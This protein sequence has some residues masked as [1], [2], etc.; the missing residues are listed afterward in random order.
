MTPNPEPQPDPAPG[1]GP[2]AR[3]NS[4]GDGKAK[5]APRAASRRPRVGD[6]LVEDGAITQAQLDRAL[7]EQRTGSRRLGELLVD[8]G[9]ISS[10]T[11]VR[12]LGRTLGVK[13]CQLRHG[14]V[15]PALL[16]LLPEEEWTRLKAI[17]MFNVQGTLT[18]AMAE[19][20][21]LPSIDRLRQMT[22]LRVR[23]VLALEANI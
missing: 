20:Q 19:P 9:T 16:K 8:Q 22:G 11:L 14:L 3:A 17:P 10:A 6:A 21:S 5:P 23:P 12:A 18:V 4:V 1:Q 7:A 13:G 2:E 15:D